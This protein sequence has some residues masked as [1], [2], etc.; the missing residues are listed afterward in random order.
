MCAKVGSVKARNNVSRETKTRAVPVFH[1][2]QP[3]G[4]VSRESLP[5]TELGKYDIQQVFDI[6]SA[7]YPADAF[8]SEPQIFRA[9]LVTGLFRRSRGLEELQCLRKQRNMPL[10]PRNQIDAFTERHF[11]PVRNLLQ[12]PVQAIPRRY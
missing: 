8:R 12:Q 5:D 1:V 6:D 10:A 7:G 2:S 4:R 11:C 3:D 9:Q